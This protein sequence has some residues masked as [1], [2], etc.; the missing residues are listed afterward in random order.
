MVPVDAAEPG[1]AAY[2]PSSENLLLPAVQISVSTKLIYATQLIVGGMI[3][4][5]PVH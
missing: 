5:S 3:V 4:I 2:S 1:S